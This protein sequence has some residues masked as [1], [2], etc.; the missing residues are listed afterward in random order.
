MHNNSLQLND[1]VG[2]FFFKYNYLNLWL[3]NRKIALHMRM[4]FYSTMGDYYQDNYR[5]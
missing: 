3:K 1:F 2:Q 5:E 4:H